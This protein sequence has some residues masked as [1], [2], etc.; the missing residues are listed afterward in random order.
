MNPQKIMIWMFFSIRN[1]DSHIEV[2]THAWNSVLGVMEKQKVITQ[3]TADG[4]PINPGTIASTIKKEGRWPFS[5][6]ANTF[7]L[8]F[9]YMGRDLWQLRITADETDLNPADWMQP[10]L[11]NNALINAWVV[12]V[13][14]DYWQNVE[15]EFSYTCMNRPHKHLPRVATG[16]PMPL[17]Q[18]V[19]DTS[20]NP[21][22]W[23]YR[24]GYVEAI[25]ATMWLGKEFWRVVPK[26]D[27]KR[28]SKLSGVEITTLE[29]DVIKV[30]AAPECFTE[31]TPK[32]LQDDLR[33]ALYPVRP[34]K[35]PQPH[36]PEGPVTTIT[37]GDT[38]ITHER[39]KNVKVTRK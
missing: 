29:N 10:F 6:K 14:F 36:I 32:K 16:A 30:V 11:N 8:E 3:L 7:Q 26:A 17:D 9:A 38:T 21:G 20:D 1:D 37:I 12:N 22:R 39:G 19:I 13:D 24:E 4:K 23:Q 2:S 33:D 25:G 15:D 34:Q 28:L 35:Y 18:E 5:L 31:T 27:R